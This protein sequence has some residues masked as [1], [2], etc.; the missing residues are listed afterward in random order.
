MSQTDG[1]DERTIELIASRVVRALK[2]ELAEIAAGIQET[3]VTE[4]A[5]TVDD[6][7][8]RFRVS[9]ST[10]YAHWREWGGYKLGAGNKSAIRFRPSTLPTGPPK[11]SQPTQPSSARL[12]RARRGRRAPV[13][14]HGEPRLPTEFDRDLTHIT[15]AD[16]A[17]S[18]RPF[19]GADA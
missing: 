9:P 13:V 18:A 1:I 3:S 2:D 16:R 8:E 7:A 17:N 11:A 5:L 19:D 4:F 14:L 15:A 12:G 10:V 6:V